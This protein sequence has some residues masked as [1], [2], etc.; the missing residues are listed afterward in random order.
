MKKILLLII[1]FTGVS[2]DEL[3]TTT[4]QLA[5]RIHAK[6]IECTANL[7]CTSPLLSK[8]YKNRGYAFAWVKDGE[9]TAS[10]VALVKSIQNANMDGFDPR[11]YHVEQ[12]N[13][14]VAKLNKDD[15]YLAVNLELTL[16]DGLFLYLN[17]LVY[18]LKNGKTLYPT[19]PIAKKN[20]DLIA[21]AN[22]ITQTEEVNK[23]LIDAAPKYPGYAKL[24]EKLYDYYGIARQGGWGVI[25][26]GEILKKG[27]KGNRV[28]L[29]QKR[30]YV[31]GELSEIDNAGEF[32]TDLEKAVIKYQQNNGLSDDGIVSK[33]TLNSLNTPVAKRIRQI[34]LNMDRMR[35]LPD[36]YPTRY[37]RVNIPDYSLEAYEDN[38]TIVYSSVV[39]GRPNK[40]T[41]VLN[42]KIIMAELNPYWNIPTSIV[43]EILPEIQANPKYLAEN[44]IKIFRVDSDNHYNRVNPETIDWKNPE[45]SIYSLRFREDPGEDNALGQFKF[46]F[47]NSCGIYLHDSIAQSAFDE[48]RRGLSHG[49]IR[50]AEVEDFANYLL[51]VNS[52]WDNKRLSTEI[53]SKKHQFIKLSTPT[54]LYVIYLTAWYDKDEDFVQFRDDIYHYD[55]PQDYPLYLP[56]NQS[57]Q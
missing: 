20:V 38:D 10:G 12:I 31:S 8:F 22:N 21:I 37:V 46:I 35:F 17:N 51:K 3:Y 43:K 24:R 19:W 15:A 33:Q 6:P 14:M 50:V 2:A 54:Q 26:S 25:P 30:L 39:V 53:E 55:R 44:G 52:G 40:K 9:L 18:G 28:S 4:H 23:V 16:S 36:N 34:E 32:D 41:C 42:S 48:T 47:P 29:L 1:A 27:A 49:C 7:N 57:I 5:N 56:K 13:K 45:S 11:D